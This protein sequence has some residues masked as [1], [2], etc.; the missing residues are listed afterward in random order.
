MDEDYKKKLLSLGVYFGNKEFNLKP[1]NKKHGVEIE[2]IVSTNSLGEF[3]YTEQLYQ[4]NFKHGSVSFDNSFESDLL[5]SL[6]DTKDIFNL[7]ECIFLDTETTGLS[8]SGG[9]FPFMVG[10]GFFF[11]HNF[12]L[13]QYFLRDPIEEEAMLLDLI[14]YL[15]NYSSLITYNGISFDIPILKSRYKYHR[16]PN[17]LNKKYH[18]DL[19]KYARMLFRY[20]FD[21]RSLKSIEAKVLQFQRS[22]DEIPGFMAPILYQEY[23]KSKDFGKVLGIFYHNAMDIVSLAALV[24]IVNQIALAQEDHFLRYE[25]LNY[26][27]GR[28]FEKNKDVEKAINVY[29]KALEQNNLPPNIKLSCLLSLGTLYKKTNKINEA[30]VIWKHAAEYQSIDAFIELAKIFEHRYKEYEH[31]INCCKDA[32]FIL[33]NDVNSIYKSLQ[34]QKINHRLN[35]LKTKVQNEKI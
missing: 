1:Q 24:K 30:V 15:A 19:L 22:E 20:Q 16:I 2:G 13:R 21:D 6:P 4:N 31:A 29:L 10:I 34:V 32:L 23:L 17:T 35:R 14:N 28:Q 27:I 18:I 8:I 26:S 25:T 3:F 12:I 33:D 7:N 9:T 5:I 11:N